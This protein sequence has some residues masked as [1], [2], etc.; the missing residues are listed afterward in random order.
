MTPAGPIRA[1]ELSGAVAWLNVP[2]PLTL[3]A[4]RG[5][6]VLLDFWTYGCINCIHI[7]PD[8]KKLEARFPD[9]LVVIG[10]HAAKFTNEQATA[11]IR[12][13]IRR[14]E[15]AH[16][17]A[18]DAEFRIWRAYTVRAWPSRVIIDPAGYI[19]GAASGE[20]NYEGFEQAIEAV[21]RVFDERGEMNRQPLALALEAEGAAETPLKFP[22][23]VHA[24]ADRLYIADSNHHQIVV[25]ALDGQLVDRIG[26]GRAGMRDGDFA[27]AE[28]RKPQ[29]LAMVDGR[30]W[31][32][33]TENHLLRQ[34]DFGERVVTTVAGIGEQCM[35]EERGGKAT[36]VALNSPWD[37][38]P[39]GGLV[40][41][42]MAGPHQIW[43]QDVMHGILWPYAGSGREARADGPIEDA[44]FA[45]PSGLVIDGQTLYVADAESNVIRAISL[46]PANQVT[47]LCGGD[48][49]EFGD[50]D[51]TADEVRLQH[52]LGVAIHDGRVVVADTYNHKIKLLDPKTRNVWTL[53]G[54]GTPGHRDGAGKNAQFY[55]PGGV[56]V[57]GD[58]IYV[59]DT[60]NHAIRAVDA[61]SG[62][63][64][65]VHV[66]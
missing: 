28:F 49:F 52:P 51:G 53:A 63:V 54:T 59:A 35:W 66:R 3:A 21:I 12:Q 37:V 61:R 60:N 34:I 44:A 43:M 48:L 33:D 62:Q 58:A 19:V 20:G 55:E 25:T 30:L 64:S 32:A 18:N 17:V 8:L 40:F 16:P 65:T 41:V 9:E 46:P 2:G 57:R 45:Q 14:Y 10:I 38:V 29:G 6:V 39:H 42:A 5:K 11:N 27:I 24:H 47:T 56:S 4:L 26:S 1:P 23:K 15:I 31:V 50:Q 22:G 13:I 36:T 7:L